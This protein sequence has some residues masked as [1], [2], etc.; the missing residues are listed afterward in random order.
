MCTVD[1][2]KKKVLTEEKLSSAELCTP[3]IADKTTALLQL[4][5]HSEA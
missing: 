3:G 4:K 2:K 1:Y 5:L